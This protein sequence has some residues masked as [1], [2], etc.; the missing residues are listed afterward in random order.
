MKHWKNEVYNDCKAP[1]GRLQQ[2]L[3]LEM[4]KSQ[5]CSGWSCFPTVSRNRHPMA[6]KPKP[7][8]HHWIVKLCNQQLNIYYYIVSR[9]FKS[10]MCTIYTK[11]CVCQCC[12]DSHL[13]SC[14]IRI[15][16]ICLQSHL[17]SFTFHYDHIW[18]W[19]PWLHNS[20][21]CPLP[22]QR[23]TLPALI[24]SLNVTS[25]FS[26]ADHWISIY[27]CPKSAKSHLGKLR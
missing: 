10:R 15:V 3:R 12:Y 14:S 16:V 13:Q 8:V 26:H 23:C 19:S 7:Y 21:I 6:P 2:L 20:N 17:S 4:L 11:S 9:C 25:P 5:G 22:W 24:P 18:L 27:T 1:W